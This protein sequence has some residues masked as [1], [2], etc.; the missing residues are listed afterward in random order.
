MAGAYRRDKNDAI[1]HFQSNFS[2]GLVICFALPSIIKLR[3]IVQAILQGC[4]GKL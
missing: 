1:P 4:F 2:H 3:E